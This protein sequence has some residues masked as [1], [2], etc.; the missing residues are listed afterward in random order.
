MKNGNGKVTDPYVISDTQT[1]I[2]IFLLQKVC[3]QYDLVILEAR[4]I[5]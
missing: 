3:V 2:Y 4:Y 5:S 1:A